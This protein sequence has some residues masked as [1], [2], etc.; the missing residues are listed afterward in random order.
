MKKVFLLG[1][2]AALMV[3]VLAVPA[4]AATPTEIYN[5]Y[6]ADGDLDG[7]YT[8]AELS[9]VLDDAMLEAYSAQDVLGDLRNLVRQTL[10]G[11]GDTTGDDT[12]G[13]RTTFPFTGFE[14]ALA[15]LGSVALIG[16]GVAIRR[17]AR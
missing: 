1:A 8:D 17:S 2:A 15:L 10:A 16:G 3:L 12:S 4:M 11:G 9:A 5:D 7:D 14:I 6:A 13:G